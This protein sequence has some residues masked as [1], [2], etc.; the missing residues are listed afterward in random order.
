M[1]IDDCRGPRGWRWLAWVW[2][3]VVLAVAL[4]QVRFWQTSDVDTDVLALLPQDAHDPLLAQA[5]NRIADQSARNVVVL[6][7][8]GDADGT[9]AAQAAFEAALRMHAP[10]PI[11]VD[12]SMHDWFGQAESF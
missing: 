4:H 2:L 5:T 7:G 12:S 10:L 6:L 3:A 1:P 9:R 11:I 8:A